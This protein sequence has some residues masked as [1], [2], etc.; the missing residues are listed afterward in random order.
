MLN[1][2]KK[3]L[4]FESNLSKPILPETPYEFITNPPAKANTEAAKLARQVAQLE[5]NRIRELEKIQW[6]K[7]RIDREEKTIDKAIRNSINNG[8]FEC[9]FRDKDFYNR[10]HY[11]TDSFSATYLAARKFRTRGFK[12][13][14]STISE[15]IYPDYNPGTSFLGFKYTITISWK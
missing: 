5:Y 11:S 15:T 7:D 13:K 3:I 8:S 6:F 10:K 2:L 4:N 14:L 12:V 9:A 1:F